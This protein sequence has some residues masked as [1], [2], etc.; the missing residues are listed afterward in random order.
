[1]KRPYLL[2]LLLG[3]PLVPAGA[4]DDIDAAARDVCRCLEVPYQDVEQAI[5]AILDAQ[6]SGDRSRVAGAQERMMR[7]IA[8]SS[9]CFEQ[10]TR[11]YP[12][13]DASD[14]LKRQVMQA[15]DQLCPNPAAAVRLQR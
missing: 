4:A 3:V 1:M 5:R 13:V 6:T 12:A 8:E 11:K 9:Q 7:S 2:F 10:L 15:A 14:D